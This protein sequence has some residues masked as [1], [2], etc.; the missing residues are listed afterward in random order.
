MKRRNLIL[1][2]VVIALLLIGVGFALTSDTLSINGTAVVA[3]SDLTVE[4]ADENGDKAGKT[5]TVTVNL[6]SEARETSATVTVKNF[7]SALSAQLNELEV[8]YVD[9]AG[10]FI[11]VTPSYLEPTLLASGADCEIKL[12]VNLIKVPADA[13]TFTFTVTFNATSVAA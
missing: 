6:S 4:F 2:F 7:S 9:G 5:A 12:V 8:A 13:T 10:E 11:E 3:A 1:S